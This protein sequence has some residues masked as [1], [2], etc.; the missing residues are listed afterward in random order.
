MRSYFASELRAIAKSLDADSPPLGAGNSP[1]QSPAQLTAGP[2][3]L[4]WDAA[5]R[6]LSCGGQLI[7]QFR[8]LAANQERLLAA[9]EE[10]SWIDIIDD[11]LPPAG[12]LEP[13]ERLRATVKSLNS[14]HKKRLIRFH[15]CGAGTQ[16]VW[17]LVRKHRQRNQPNRRRRSPAERKPKR[18]GRR[19]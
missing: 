7:K 17:K 15:V 14:G 19:H 1:A 3:K 2:P 11:P 9:F 4:R 10:S 18:S 13:K 5:R 16:V 6:E 8:M 12:D